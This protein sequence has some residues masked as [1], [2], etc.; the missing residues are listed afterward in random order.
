MIG[1]F[2]AGPPLREP[3]IIEYGLDLVMTGGEAGEFERCRR[4]WRWFRCSGK[5]L[6]LPLSWYAARM[7]QVSRHR[8]GRGHIKG[9]RV[10]WVRM[11]GGRTMCNVLL[12]FLQRGRHG[13]D[14]AAAGSREGGDENKTV[15]TARRRRF[16][17]A[18]HRHHADIMGGESTLR[19]CDGPD[20]RMLG[21]G[22]KGVHLRAG[23]WGFAVG[24][25]DGGV[26]F[27]VAIEEGGGIWK[28]QS[29]LTTSKAKWPLASTLAVVSSAQSGP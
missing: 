18:A 11:A 20:D 13:H 1:D 24:E 23:G 28:Y 25:E 29:P 4:R 26:E 19:V 17:I 8:E 14:H 21:V 6:S 9:L 22:K 2:Q 27:S 15:G 16:R 7:R 12:R 10:P 5:G 3:E